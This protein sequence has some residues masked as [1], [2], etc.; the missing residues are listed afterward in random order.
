MDE[1]CEG[2]FIVPGVKALQELPIRQSAAIAQQSQPAK[3]SNKPMSSPS[4]HD[5]CTPASVPASHEYT[6]WRQAI[7]FNFLSIQGKE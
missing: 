7:S 6:A 3:L 1:C 2:G 5:A 4:R